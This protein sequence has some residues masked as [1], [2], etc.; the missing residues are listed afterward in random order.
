MNAE[1]PQNIEHV[2]AFHS[3][4]HY[5]SVLAMKPNKP[6]TLQHGTRWGQ[7]PGAMAGPMQ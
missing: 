5:L 7:P 3:A 2:T 6:D 4:F 1:G